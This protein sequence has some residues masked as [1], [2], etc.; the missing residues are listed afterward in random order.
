MTIQVAHETH[1]RFKGPGNLGFSC[2]S[3]ATVLFSSV[4][5]P[6]SAEASYTKRLVYNSELTV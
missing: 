5:R 4:V 1:E 2:V 6:A 3:W